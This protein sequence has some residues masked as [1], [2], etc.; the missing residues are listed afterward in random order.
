[1]LVNHKSNTKLHGV[2]VSRSILIKHMIHS[3]HVPVK[4]TSMYK[5]MKKYSDNLLSV[6]STWTSIEKHGRK[7]YL[8]EHSFHSLINKIKNSTDSGFVLSLGDIRDM[9]MKCIKTKWAIK[10]N[11]INFQMYPSIP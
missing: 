11:S 3:K 8:S 6:K 2:S 10:K 1:M 5:L 7:S 9:V 4:T